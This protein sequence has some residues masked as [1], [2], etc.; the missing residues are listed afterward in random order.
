MGTLSAREAARGGRHRRREG[1]ERPAR[2]LQRE[3]DDDADGFAPSPLESSLGF[4]GR[5][6]SLLFS[7]FFYF[8]SVFDL[9]EVAN[10]LQIL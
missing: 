8:F 10:E 7:V 2:S 5:S 6:F 4:A 9:I 3:E 1:V